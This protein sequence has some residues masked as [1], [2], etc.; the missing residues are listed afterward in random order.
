M[1]ADDK[2]FTNISFIRSYCFIYMICIQ[3]ILF[4]NLR[5]RLMFKSQLNSSLFLYFLIAYI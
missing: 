4:F 1:Q 5:L 2:A 3:N